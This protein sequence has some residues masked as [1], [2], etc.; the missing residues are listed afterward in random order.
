MKRMDE[1]LPQM[2][3]WLIHPHGRYL[4]EAER[5][6]LAAILPKYFGY[7]L[8]QI[9][10][11]VHDDYV[12][13]SLIDHRIRLT[14]GLNRHFNGCSVQS[15]VYDLPFAPDSIDVVLLPHILEYVKEP[16]ALLQTVYDTL[17]P[18][19][20]VIIVCFNPFSWW[21]VSKKIRP[22]R[23]VGKNA[24]F[25]RAARIRRW[26]TRIGFAIV[27]QKSLA[28][29]IPFSNEKW[30]NNTRFME[31]LGQLIMPACG[32]VNIIVAQKR[33]LKTL[34]VDARLTPKPVSIGA[35]EPT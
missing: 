27:R 34:P 32:A 12:Q 20:H 14:D 22:M 18:D 19:G 4:Y 2:D 11:P 28:F 30:I 24:R 1:N 13:A 15:S 33:I 31:P 35:V 6:Y 17:I 23:I 10:G 16:R 7:H 5:H 9:G 21:G 3:Q 25:Y 26:L 29:R 8:L